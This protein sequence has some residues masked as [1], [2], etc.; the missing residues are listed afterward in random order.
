VAVNGLS[1]LKNILLSVRWRS[2]SNCKI[3]SRVTWLLGDHLDFSAQFGGAL[4]HRGSPLANIEI[5]CGVEK[6]NDCPSHRF[7]ALL[8]C[9]V[10]LANLNYEVDWRMDVFVL[11]LAEES[12]TR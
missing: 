10:K 8:N 9:G 3:Q 7:E 12:D 2:N 5:A 1:S 11:M 6:T 4:E